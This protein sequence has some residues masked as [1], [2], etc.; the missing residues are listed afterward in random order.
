M[1][2]VNKIGQKTRES[3]IIQCIKDP[4]PFEEPMHHHKIINF[5]NE[6][7]SHSFGGA[8]NKLMELEMVRDLF[9]NILYLAS[10]RKNYMTEV[11]LFP[12]TPTPLSL[13]HADGT[14]LKTKKVS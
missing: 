10:Q 13:S 6:G 11:C 7:A 5:V 8:N 2:N 12:L 4:K 9:G 14:M 1:L 3:F